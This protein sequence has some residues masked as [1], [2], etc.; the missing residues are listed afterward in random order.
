MVTSLSQ[1]TR[2][3]LS[4]SHPSHHDYQK[5][6]AG[7]HQLYPIRFNLYAFRISV[8]CVHVPVTVHR[9][10]QSRISYV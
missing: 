9:S 8:T 3:L 7:S 2:F 10:G 1:F 4:G 5:R 6:N